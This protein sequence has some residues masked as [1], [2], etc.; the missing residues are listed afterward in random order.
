MMQHELPTINF[1]AEAEVRSKAEHRRTEEIMELLRPILNR[2]AAKFHR[3][4][5]AILHAVQY[6][7]AAAGAVNRQV[8]PGN[9]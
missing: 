5:L 4:K 9:G 3:R 2:W 7:P 6:I 1:V 8:A